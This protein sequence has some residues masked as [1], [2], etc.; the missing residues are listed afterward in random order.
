VFESL[1]SRL[2]LDWE[3]ITTGYDRRQWGAWPELGL[4]AER[5]ISRLSEST[6]KAQKPAP[7]R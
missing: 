6:A 2:N 3:L 1:L 4:N 5:T 7:P